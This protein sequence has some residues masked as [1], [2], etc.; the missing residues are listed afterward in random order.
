M[1]ARFGPISLIYG[2]QVYYHFP[3]GSILKKKNDEL[4]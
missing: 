2:L 1:G 4:T 3:H